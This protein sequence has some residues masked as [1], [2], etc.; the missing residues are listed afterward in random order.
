M[1]SGGDLKRRKMNF[2]AISDELNDIFFEF[3]FSV[4]DYYALVTRALATLEGIAL[5]GDP[6]FDIFWAAYPYALSRAISLLGP[7]RASGLLSA[8]TA[9]AAMNMTASER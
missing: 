7:R 9:R 3:P 2:A 8:A 1:K 4:P 5:V 6:N